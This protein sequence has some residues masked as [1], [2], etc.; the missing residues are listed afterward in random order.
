[1]IGADAQNSKAVYSALAKFGAP[2]EGISAKDFAEPDNFFRMG[3]PPGDELDQIKK[4]G[5][6]DWLRLRQQKGSSPTL[7]EFQAKGRE[8]R[9][10]LRQQRTWENSRDSQDRSAET[11]HDSK[12]KDLSPERGKGIDDDLE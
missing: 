5:R 2:V 1:L 7:E 9:L 11:D 10:K 6:E 8:D 12:R 3:T 4:Q